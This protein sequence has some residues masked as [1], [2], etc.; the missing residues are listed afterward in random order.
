MQSVVD[1]KHVDSHSLEIMVR[2]VFD[3]EIQNKIRT[4]PNQND[5]EIQTVLRYMQNRIDEISKKYK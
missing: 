1:T 4:K 3:Y 5:L 2:H